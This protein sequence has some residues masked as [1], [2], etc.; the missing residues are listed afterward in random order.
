MSGSGM[1]SPPPQGPAQ[2]EQQADE[3]AEGD[4]PGAPGGRVLPGQ[5]VLAVR[6]ADRVLVEG[7]PAVRARDRVAPAHGASPHEKTTAPW[8]CSRARGPGS[9]LGEDGGAGWRSPPALSSVSASCGR[10][11]R[12][13]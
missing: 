5:V 3:D 4:P 12:R 10:E 7:P 1:G 6:A 11:G 9:R 13:A 2:G 8:D